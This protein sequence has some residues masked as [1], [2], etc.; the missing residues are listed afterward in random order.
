MA[1]TARA[2]GREVGLEER[3][4]A[5]ASTMD[6]VPPGEQCRFIGHGQ[7]GERWRGAIGREEV[8]TGLGR[9]MGRLDEYLF[10]GLVEVDDDVDVVAS[11]GLG[12]A[13]GMSR[14]RFDQLC[15][16]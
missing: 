15:H 16:R 6:D 11:V 10:G 7:D 3:T 1:M 13:L 2:Q 5:D 12:R 8:G 14:I 9:S 4:S